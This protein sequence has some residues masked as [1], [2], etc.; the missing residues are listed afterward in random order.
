MKPAI[1]SKIVEELVETGTLRSFRVI[2]SH[3]HMGAFSGIWFPNPEPE[4][5]L[6]TLDRCGVEWLAFAHHD[7][8][9][10]PVRGNQKAQSRH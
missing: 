8:M 7:A 10:D 9:Q 5:M 6:R 3:G 2:D 4:D 1:K